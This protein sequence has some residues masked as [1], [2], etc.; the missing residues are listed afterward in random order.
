MTARRSAPRRIPDLVVLKFGGSS[1]DGG[2]KI[3]GV[4]ELV[5]RR[6]EPRLVVVSAMGKITSEL[7]RLAVLAAIDKRRGV[8]T[9]HRGLD[10]LVER[11]RRALVQAAGERADVEWVREAIAA[12]A[13]R[14]AELLE[15]IGAAGEVAPR[16][17]DG[18]VSLGELLS[19]RIVAAALAARGLDVQWID[20]R[21]LIATDDRFGSAR[22]DRA[23]IFRQ[24]QALAC[25]A[26]LGGKVVVT[27]GYV[28]RAAD[29]ETTTM[30][31]ESSDLTATLLGGALRAAA[32]EIWTDVDGILTADPRLVPEARLIPALSYR[33]AACLARL[34]AKVIH[35][36]TVAPA[37]A[38]GAVVRIR[39]RFRPDAAGSVIGPA[40]ASTPLWG[41]AAREVLLQTST[42]KIVEALFPIDGSWALVTGYR[43]GSVPLQLRAARSVLEHVGKT[44]RVLVSVVG[45]VRE[46]GGDLEAEVRHALHDLDAVP[47][48]GRGVAISYLLPLGE[49]RVAV[50]RLHQVAFA[51]V[52]A[53]ETV[54]A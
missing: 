11:H 51:R 42:G 32:V 46:V 15:R 13:D 14:V 28:G 25:P 7:Q 26:L 19:S 10:E 35:P 33:E 24:A 18:V 3:A 38:V 22:P 31:R 45:R 37:A 47:V 43:L 2:E 8:E 21:D 30:G 1:V 44:A 41:I 4:A 29:G 6:S 48:P 52:P 20:P 9:A 23:R 12:E 17:E 5:T 49:A 34:G 40:P 54:L 16:H 27:G 50:E 53:E 36:D 39:N